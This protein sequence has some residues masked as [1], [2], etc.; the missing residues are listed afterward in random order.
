[1]KRL[2]IF[3]VL[4]FG[5]LT[6][7]AKADPRQFYYDTVGDWTIGG[8]TASGDI[9]AHC[10]LNRTF[11]DGSFFNLH[12]NLDEDGDLYIYI[13]NTAW[14]IAG[15]TDVVASLR[16]NFYTKDAFGYGVDFQFRVVNKNSIVI[17]KINKAVY[18]PLFVK[19]TSSRFIMPGDVSNIELP[20]DGS[21]AGYLKLGECIDLS[22]RIDLNPDVLSVPDRSL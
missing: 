15:Q 12:R 8:Y 22:T 2:W 13:H 17:P 3:L 19:Y 6:S 9:P 21:S 18:V 5:L 4:A 20:L 16:N 11:A 1:M 10:T 7:T 14:N